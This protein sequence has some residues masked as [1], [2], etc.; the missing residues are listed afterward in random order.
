MYFGSITLND[1]ESCFSQPKL[2]LYNLFCTLCALKMYLIGVQNLVVEVDTRYIKGMLANP[3]LALS[4]SMNCWI[5][6][7]LLFHFTLIHVPGTWHG[8]DG[9]LQ[10]PQQL[11]NNITNSVDNLEFSDWDDQVYGF[12]H[13]LNPLSPTI[14]YPKICMTYVSETLSNSSINQGPTA[15]S[16]LSYTVV[17]WLSKSQ[18]ADEHL[19]I[20]CNWFVSMQSL[21]NIT[22]AA[23]TAP[24]W[25]SMYFFMK[26]SHL[27]KKDA[28]GCHKVVIDPHRWL[29]MLVAAH[30]NLGHHS[31]DYVMQSH[32]INWFWWPDLSANIAWF[33]KTCHVCQLHQMHNILIPPVIATPVPLFAKMYM[34]TR[35]LLKSGGF[36]YLVQGHCLLTHFPEYHLLCAE[37]GKMIGD[38]IFEDILCW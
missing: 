18:K 19:H 37:T 6:S 8:P 26:D 34:D 13:F 20:L 31:R 32:L 14:T 17:P 36:K 7:I 3:D 21:D 29:L 9:L 22:D 1:H 4:A 5:I 12:M 33:V 25:Y 24:L 23:Y 27:W 11:S 2:E 15:N 38:W 16:P 10:C 28:Q 30:D 35:H